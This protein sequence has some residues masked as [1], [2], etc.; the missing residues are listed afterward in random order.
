MRFADDDNAPLPAHVTPLQAMM[1]KMAGHNVPS[2]RPVEDRDSDDDNEYDKNAEE[3][4][5]LDIPPR[6][7]PPGPPPGKITKKISF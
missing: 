7:Q 5:E 2:T 4:E 1:L 3:N 6:H